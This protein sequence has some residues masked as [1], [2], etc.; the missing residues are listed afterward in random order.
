MIQNL[1]IILLVILF[2]IYFTGS[3]LAQIYGC[4]DPNA[5]NYN[6]LAT[7]NDGSCTYDP[8]IYNPPF[9]MNLPETVNETSGLILYNNGLWTHNDSGGDAN[10]YKI[11]TVSSEIV[12]TIYLTNASNFDWEDIT[13]DEDFIYIG[14]FGNNE[15]NRRNLRIYK[16]NKNDIP[17]SGNENVNSEI[18]HFSYSDQTDFSSAYNNNN[19]DCEAIISC[20]DYLYLFSKNWENY[21]T[22]LYKLSKIP[23]TYEAALIDSFNVNGL[24]T[25]A[26]YNQEF[27]EISLIAYKN[28]IP[29]MFL[30]YNYQGN[31]FFSGNKRRIDF[32]Y[33]YAAQTEGIT[34]STER[35]VLISCENSAETQRVFK[36]NTGIW[37]NIS[38]VGIEEL[39]EVDFDFSISPNPVLK[40]KFKIDLTN[41]PEQSFTIEFYDSLGQKVNFKPRKYSGSDGK[42]QLSFKVGKS[43]PGLYL[44]RVRS[45]DKYST[46]KLIIQ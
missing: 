41:L 17:S 31:N 16:V 28:Y 10:I 32:P 14:D 29:F 12:Q 22:R 39:T 23:G 35:Y 45:D 9:F 37:T 7:I 6:P 38:P 20:E 2:N 13:Q 1:K 21:K 8:T 24:I 42:I 18:I 40:K 19:Y 25:G 36:V 11:D 43:K 34:Y 15:G 30:L 46:R 27:N 33:I 5:N 4:T 44:V 3:S 26:T